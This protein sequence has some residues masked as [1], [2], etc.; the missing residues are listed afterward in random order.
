MKKLTLLMTTLLLSTSVFASTQTVNEERHFQTNTFTEKSQAYTA[1]FDYLDS[2]NNLS[3]K[4]LRNKLVA[5]NPSPV[6]D[7]KIDDAKVYV[8][9]FAEDRGQI[10]YRA[11]VDVNYHYQAHESNE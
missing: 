1:G 11:V 3:Q 4:E 6:S 10:A 2:I 5:I 9:E 7:I 8:N